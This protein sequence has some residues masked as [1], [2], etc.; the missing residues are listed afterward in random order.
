LESV[1]G[2]EA[3]RR[4]EFLAP[5][6]AEP[7]RSDRLFGQRLLA[8]LVKGLDSFRADNDKRDSR[9]ALP[10]VAARVLFR[11]S[12]Y[13]VLGVASGVSAGMRA[14]RLEGGFGH[15]PVD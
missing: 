11:V 4:A 12:Q 13:D 2:T 9:L 6:V 8:T 15:V 5:L 10:F 14:K 7:N 1:E 3:L